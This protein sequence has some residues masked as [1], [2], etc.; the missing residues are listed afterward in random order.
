[1]E[2]IFLKAKQKLVKEITTEGTKPYPLAK[3]FTSQ[4]YNIQPN[5]KGFEE[6]Y[7]L[8]QTHSKAGHALHKGDLKKKLKQISKM[9]RKKHQY[10]IN[11]LMKH[12]EPFLRNYPQT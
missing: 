12:K 11:P 7:N 8:L 2:I 10:L 9:K 6:F 5:T 4:H 3:T 1:M